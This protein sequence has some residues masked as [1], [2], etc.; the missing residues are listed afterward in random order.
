MTEISEAVLKKELAPRG[1]PANTSQAVQK[2]ATT[3][4]EELDKK[5]LGYEFHV[6]TVLAEHN[7]FNESANVHYTD[8]TEEEGMILHSTKPVDKVAMDC[9]NAVLG[10]K[11]RSQKIDDV[12]KGEMAKIEQKQKELIRQTI[13][14]EKNTKDVAETKKLVNRLMRGIMTSVKDSLPGL[15]WSIFVMVLPAIAAYE[16]SYADTPGTEYLKCEIRESGEEFNALAVVIGS[17]NA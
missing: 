12:V 6:I 4:F 16:L 15:K 2:V 14:K 7:G 11:R 17:P 9:V 5:C 8:K 1:G 10:I 3:T 13:A